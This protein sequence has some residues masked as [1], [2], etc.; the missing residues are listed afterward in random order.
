ME[1]KDGYMG[2]SES[3]GGYTSSRLIVKNLPKHM[4]E[5]KMNK[6]FSYDGKF[7]VTD[8]KICR[9]GAKSRQFGFVGFKSE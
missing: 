5:E 8:A 4:T 6:H 2:K 3:Q 7:E 9:K 1:T